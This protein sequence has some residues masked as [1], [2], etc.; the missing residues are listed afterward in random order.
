MMLQAGD[1]ARLREQYAQLES[2]YNALALVVNTTPDSAQA[3]EVKYRLI[4]PSFF[5]DY[6][7]LM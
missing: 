5:L 7:I 3:A 4:L 1:A 2:Q 6:Q